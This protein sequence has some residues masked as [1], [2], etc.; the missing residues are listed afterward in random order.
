[1]SSSCGVQAPRN[2][3]GAQ[4]ERLW[5]ILGS[6]SFGAL[7]FPVWGSRNRAKLQLVPLLLKI[8]WDLQIVCWTWQSCSPQVLAF[9]CLNPIVECR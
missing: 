7:I 6:L 4:T 5:L 8:H 3:R 2:W 1:M 9:T